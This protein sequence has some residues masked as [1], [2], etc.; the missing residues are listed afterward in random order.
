[1]IKGKI[2]Y[3]PPNVLAELEVIKH[4]YNLDSDAHA[5]KKMAEL[6]PIGMEFEKMRERFFL[7]DLFKKK[8]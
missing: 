2:K 5:F 6:S 7:M 4:N 8:K 3:V 1:M